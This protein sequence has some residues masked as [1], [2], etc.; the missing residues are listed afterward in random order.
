MT[1][2]IVKTNDTSIDVAR[3]VQTIFPP[4]AVTPGLLAKVTG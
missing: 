1:A 3:P 4:E 2:L